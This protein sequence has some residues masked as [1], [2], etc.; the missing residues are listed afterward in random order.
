MGPTTAQPCFCPKPIFPM[1][2]GL[3]AASHWLKR[4]EAMDLYGRIRE[5]AKGRDLF[6]LHD[7]PIYANGDIHSA[8]G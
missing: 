1:K 6:V 2:A 5:S 4:W 8:P 7:G 3:P